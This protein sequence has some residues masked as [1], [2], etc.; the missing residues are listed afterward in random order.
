M[1]VYIDQDN[2]VHFKGWRLVED[3]FRRVS[4]PIL[5]LPESAETEIA[6]SPLL[7]AA[8]QYG[9]DN[10][11][12]ENFGSHTTDVGPAVDPTSASVSVHYSLSDAASHVERS[13]VAADL[14][15]NAPE[16]AEAP[17]ADGTK[18]SDD[19]SAAAMLLSSSDA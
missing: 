17:L 11:S 9:I 4:E 12:S 10:A 5:P 8:L 7:W 15:L 3:S 13:T 18:L 19:F 6:E 16:S 2:I 14:L 1:D